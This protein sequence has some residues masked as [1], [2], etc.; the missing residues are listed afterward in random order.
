MLLRVL[1]ALPLVARILPAAPAIEIPEGA[2]SFQYVDEDGILEGSLT[3]WTYR[4]RGLAPAARILFALHGERRDARGNRDQLQ[5][6]AERHGFLLV[7]PEFDEKNFSEYAYQRGG[8][9][10]DEGNA[11]EK[12]RW[13]FGVI[14][15]LF[16]A[17][18]QSARLRTDRYY[19]YGHSA[20]AQF[21][22]RFVLFMPEARYERA[23][24]ANAGWYTLPRFDE[25]FPYG[26]KGTSVTEGDL[27]R[28]MARDLVILLGDQ[29]TDVS[30]ASLRNTA[31]AQ[32]QGATRLERG[33]N[34]FAAARTAAG[35]MG[36][37]LRWR[38]FEVRGAG[39]SN[40]QLSEAAVSYLV[41]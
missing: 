29:D 28:A 37:P 17:V 22:H 32:A 36:A 24:A 8:V 9:V 26:L 39:H 7:V 12:R 3:V 4:P 31:R 6:H 18:R 27:K 38:Q 15:R 14:E 20:G 19:L 40:R 25:A 21:I 10:D 1:L 2:G 33:R 35:K 41:R 23:V 34:F 13:T 30:D 16:D 5:S 11:L